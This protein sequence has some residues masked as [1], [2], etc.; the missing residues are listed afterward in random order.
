[1]PAKM[2]FVYCCCSPL[3]VIRFS[4][5][6]GFLCFLSQFKI[7]VAHS[8]TVNDNGEKRG[9]GLETGAGEVGFG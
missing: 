9:G 8:L 4:L 5:Q 2:S 7:F 1:M 3:F 6:P